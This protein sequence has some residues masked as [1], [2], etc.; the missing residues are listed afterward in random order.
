MIAIDTSILVTARRAEA[1]FHAEAAKLPRGLAEGGA[2]WAIPWPCVYEFLRVATHPR[3]F[4]PPTR[5][6]TALEDLESLLASPSLHLL[7]EGP[8]HPSHLLAAVHGGRASGNLAHDAHI[9]ALCAEHGVGE[10]WTA[11]R[12]FARFPGLRVRNPLEPE[13]HERGRGYAAG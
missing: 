11:D 2:P 8:S 5:L 13:I 9:V 7:G 4:D 1:P 6:E 12:D 3:V 10:L